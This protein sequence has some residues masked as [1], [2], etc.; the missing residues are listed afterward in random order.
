MGCADAARGP[1]GA[2]PGFS[3]FSVVCMV[4]VL[5]L[6]GAYLVR[7]F[8]SECRESMQRRARRIR[9]NQKAGG[10]A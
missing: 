1:A 6:Q 10:A 3:L 8:N 7:G 5:R 2:P 4:E 9:C